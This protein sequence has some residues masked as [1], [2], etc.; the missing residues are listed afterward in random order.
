MASETH[1][2]PLQTFEESKV[3]GYEVRDANVRGLVGFGVGLAVLLVIIVVGMIFTFQH[4]A[5]TQNLGP[6]A[7]PFENSRTIP[8]LPRLQAAPHTDIL[9]YWESQQKA[10]NSYGWVDRQKGVAHIPIDEA[11]RLVLQRGLP[12]R[13]NAPADVNQDAASHVRT[14]A[15]QMHGRPPGGSQ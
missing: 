2:D 3:E 4:F 11:M 6:T 5:H 12:V 7:S 9:D 15:S 10:L 8:P 13:A 1:N 14:E